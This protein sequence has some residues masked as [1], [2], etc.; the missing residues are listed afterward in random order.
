MIGEN[1]VILNEETV[2]NMVKGY[3]ENNLFKDRGFSV[4]KITKRSYDTEWT[5]TLEGKEVADATES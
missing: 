4:T 5:I 3:L 1:T 2:K